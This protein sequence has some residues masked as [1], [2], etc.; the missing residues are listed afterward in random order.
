[1]Y[2]SVNYGIQL[3]SSLET[4]VTTVVI[5][6]IIPSGRTSQTLLFLP[7]RAYNSLKCDNSCVKGIA[8]EAGAFPSYLLQ[9]ALESLHNILFFDLKCTPYFCSCMMPAHDIFS[10][11][12]KN[13]HFFKKVIKYKIIKTIEFCF[14]NIRIQCLNCVCVEFKK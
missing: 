2:F 1:M 8:M 4:N 5:F 12:S 9:F 10:E 13:S 14:Q 3:I 7:L 6:R 11:I